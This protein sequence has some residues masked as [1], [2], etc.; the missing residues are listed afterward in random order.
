MANY[1]YMS[2]F[3][4]DETLA[5]T[6]GFSEQEICALHE[7][8]RPC[9][10]ASSRHGDSADRIAAILA[11]KGSDHSH[12]DFIASKGKWPYEL[13]ADVLPFDELL[14]IAES[15]DDL[16]A[17]SARSIPVLTRILDNDS[18]EEI[19]DALQA[20]AISANPNDGSGVDFDGYGARFLFSFLASI[21]SI[22][23]E[24]HASQRALIFFRG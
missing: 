6:S 22:A 23:R 18:A 15:I 11:A 1:L 4:C 2:L 13:W 8:K 21:A 17:W 20:P 24:A 5:R 3:F 7:G 19:A 12:L 10:R 14:P 16:L 9:F